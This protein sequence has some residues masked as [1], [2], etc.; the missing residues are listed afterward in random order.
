MGYSQACPSAMSG[1]IR[2]L[3]GGRGTS[4]PPDRV[5]LRLE[6]LATKGNQRRY[7]STNLWKSLRAPGF[8]VIIVVCARRSMSTLKRLRQSRLPRKPP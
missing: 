1:G 4:L 2:N 5:P 6:Y 7:G 8:G 3:A